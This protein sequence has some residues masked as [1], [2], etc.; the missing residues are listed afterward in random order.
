MILP[1]QSA[2]TES[3]PSN[4][5]HPPAGA[6]ARPG[7]EDLL[8]P[9]AD[10]LG[11]AWIL[12]QIHFDRARLARQRAWERTFHRLVAGSVRSLLALAGIVFATLGA[13]GGLHALYAGRP[14]QAELTTG[15][16][17]LGTVLIW[18]RLAGRTDERAARRRLAA[19]YAASKPRS[20]GGE[21][22]KAGR[23]PRVPG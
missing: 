2:R 19:K 13:R 8:A 18:G 21:H 15:L 10:A 14:W 11:Q 6:G 20:S 17:L 1:Q 22:A 3:G 7:I 9:L 16:L 4:G 5:E 12:A 23:D